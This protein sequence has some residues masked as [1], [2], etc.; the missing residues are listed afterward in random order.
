LFGA[1]IFPV[2]SPQR[3]VHIK[4]R[5]SCAG[6]V[7][8]KEEH[9]NMKTLK[10]T[11]CLV[12][13]LVMALSLLAVGGFAANNLDDYKDAD[14][15][16]YA[17]AV[18][19]LSGVGIIA[20]YDTGDFQPTTVVTREQAAKLVTYMLIGPTA[21]DALRASTDPFKDVAAS[22]WSAGYIAYCVQQGLINGY[23][24]GNFG[25]TDPVTGY[26]F[27][28]LML[29]AVGYGAKDEYTGASW[30]INVAKDAIPLKVF[31]NNIK[32]ASDVSA[33]REEAALYAF[34]TLTKIDKVSYSEL[35][36]TYTV[37][38]SVV[39][40]V[41]GETLGQ[42][43][44][45]LYKMSGTIGYG[46][47][48]N[49]SKNTYNIGRVAVESNYTDEGRAAHVWYQLENNKRVSVSGAYFD[50][51][52][53]GTYTDGTSVANATNSSK[54]VYVAD[55]EGTY[56]VYMNGKAV[57][58]ATADPDSGAT[59]DYWFDTA[60]LKLMLDAA[61]IDGKGVKVD[62]VDSA[63][64][65]TSGGTTYDVDKNGRIDKIM[66]TV[67]TTAK[68]TSYSSVGDG[69]VT[70]NNSNFGEASDKWTSK[71]VATFDDLAKGDII[72]GIVYN[73][74]LY[75][76][77]TTTDAGKTTKVTTSGSSKTY[78]VNGSDY[79]VASRA[80]GFSAPS[81][82]DKL[83]VYLDEY[84]YIVSSGD[85]EVDVANLYYLADNDAS[86]MAGTAVKLYSTT[87]AEKIVTVDKIAGIASFASKGTA[88][89]TIYSL[90]ESDG[91]YTLNAVT[92]AAVVITGTASTGDTIKKN[93]AAVSLTD[94]SSTKNLIA[95]SDTIFVD[96]ANKVAYTGYTNL[97]GD[98]SAVKSGAYVADDN[99]LK[100]VFIGS[101]TA[102][103]ATKAQFVVFDKDKYSETENSNGAKEYTYATFLDGVSADVTVDA[104]VQAL[105]QAKGAGIYEV[106]SRNSKDVVTGVTGNDIKTALTGTA[107]AYTDNATTLVVSTNGY[108]LNSDTLYVVVDLTAGSTKAEAGTADDL[109][110]GAT[111]ADN[112][113]VI[114]TAKG[115]SGTD[116][117]TAKIVYIV[118]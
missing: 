88:T 97:P 62:F 83:T 6:K 56:T 67:Y 29:C 92:P 57:Q 80:F 21:A 71:N 32:G 72:T 84:G 108:I 93:S 48:D 109:L 44:Y 64:S 95:N 94:S 37:G 102:A 17:E 103:S 61:A 28:K 82:G 110:E 14:S 74:T 1:I 104:T 18:D 78:T 73:G 66:Y 15:I 9:T 25:P 22:R 3:G 13:A 41:I 30:S 111:A 68:V 63:Y 19:V 42:S 81:V 8:F 87:G 101:G 99:I 47:A 70:F 11:L 90:S 59:G 117:L 55:L 115:T 20:G 76:T 118:K 52:V 34:N 4:P 10:K 31:D 100:V 35:L 85:V 79:A 86:T 40:T 26:Q 106:A 46:A 5:F 45:K 2:S 107:F 113:K 65:Y 98:F 114:V 53:L 75:T 24:D 33:T 50:D 38:G 36:G 49:Y 60:N 58:K 89:K 51:A 77:A 116:A 12:L 105:I 54:A 39:G 96:V 27:A 7:Y 23:G 69:K 16:Q 91:T 112:S 43:V